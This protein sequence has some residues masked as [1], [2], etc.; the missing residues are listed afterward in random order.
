[1]VNAAD[2]AAV[3]RIIAGRFAPE[4]R[5]A[6]PMAHHLRT[7]RGMQE[8]SG[9]YD[10]Q[11]VRS[12]TADRIEAVVRT[13]ARGVLH[14]LDLRIEPEPPHL[15]V[16][17]GIGPLDTRPEVPLGDAPD[18]PLSD[19]EL[20]AE[21]ETYMERLVAADRFVG[22]VL[23]AR[24]GEILFDRAYGLANRSDSVP[25]RPDTKFNLGS[26]NKMFTAITIAKLA[27]E[28]RL[29]LND[30]IGKWL[31][32]DW[33]RPEVGQKVTIEHLL[34]HT[35]G[36]GNYFTD[37]FMQASR[38]RFRDVDDYAPLV[39]QDSLRFEPGTDWSYSNTG[40]LLL[41]A[42][43]E[44]V[45][46]RSYYDIVRELVY[47]PAGM[48][49]TDAYSM[50]EV[51]P[52]LAIGY[53]P[54][55]GPDGIHWRSNLFLH[56]IRGGPAGGGFSTAPDLLR[57]ALALR[58]N[59]LLSPAWTA[60]VTTP[61]PELGSPGYGYGFQVWDGGRVGHGGG[62]PGISSVL[63]IDLHGDY[64]LIVLSNVSMGERPVSRKVEQL[65]SPPT[66]S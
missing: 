9:G 14:L 37:E 57:F 10:L 3:H 22:V 34:T 16:S 49:D 65:L 31:G 1:M 52:N 26:M 64:V 47:E 24:G 29:S 58:E 4:F 43:V 30:P 19:P 23:L 2:S 18:N 36:L 54:E 11:A 66:A 6:F 5:D 21:L 17:M 20:V 63:R 41:G 51:V 50:D 35:S 39:D 12:A 38:T 27:D 46:G 59:R 42:I 45:T 32:T 56:A 25:N 48:T 44:V 28:R 60:R 62:F 55:F 7:W 33:V 40:F 8:E 61:K 13:R 53:D 15:I